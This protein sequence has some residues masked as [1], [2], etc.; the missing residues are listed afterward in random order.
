MTSLV[1][2]KADLGIIVN[3]DAYRSATVKS[4]TGGKLTAEETNRTRTARRFEPP[5]TP[6]CSS[7]KERRTECP[8]ARNC[9]TTPAYPVGV[10]GNSQSP[11]SSHITL[12]Q[13]YSYVLWPARG[14]QITRG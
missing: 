5:S 8:T 14:G 12:R 9:P 4:T 2:S 10:P 7:S 1:R 3:C 6:P 13:A 11:R